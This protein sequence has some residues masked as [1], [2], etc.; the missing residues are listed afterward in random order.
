MPD[1]KSKLAFT[2]II[3]GMSSD[4]QRP[5]KITPWVREA[6]FARLIGVPRSTLTAWQA[7]GLIGRSAGGDYG[8]DDVVLGLMISALRE[9][10]PVPAIQQFRRALEEDGTLRKPILPREWGRGGLRLDLAADPLTGNVGICVRDEELVRAVRPS[11]GTRQRQ[12]IVIR[13]GEP[14]HRA[15]REFE[16]LAQTGQPPK[17]RSRGRPRKSPGARAN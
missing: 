15:L 1:S 14:L 17:S 3:G 4:P 7:R 11:R 16:D 10:L 2:G 13:L 9:H 5:A 8:K 6:T 12:S